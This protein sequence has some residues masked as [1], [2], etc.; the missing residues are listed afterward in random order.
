[1]FVCIPFSW[2]AG[3]PGL[4][5]FKVTEDGPLSG[6]IGN[7]ETSEK[8]FLHNVFVEGNVYLDTEDRLVMDEDGFLSFTD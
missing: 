7:K 5:V 2:P 8:K 4:L 3:E 6:Y 1:M